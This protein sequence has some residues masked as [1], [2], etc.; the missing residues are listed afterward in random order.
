MSAVG[1]LFALRGTKTGKTAL[2]ATLW[3]ATGYGTLTVSRF[4]SRLVLAKL[5]PNAAPMG[6]VAIILL[7][8]GGLELVSDLGIGVG[9]VQHPRSGERRYM[10]T[11]FSVQVVRGVGLWAIA[12]MMAAPI[13]SL[14]HAP[15]LTGLLLFGAISTLIKAFG[16]PALW[17]HT[18][19]MTLRVPTL[20]TIA[21]ELAGFV[22]TIGWMLL[23]PTAWAIVG[24]VVATAAVSTLASHL[25]R[26]RAEFLWDKK[27]AKEIVNFGGWMVLSSATY[28]MSSRGESLM[29]RG[30]VPDIEFG[31]F[32]FASM[33]VTTP[34]AAVTA[35][36]NQVYL[37]MLAS[38]VREDANR[39]RRLFGLG[40][41][42]FTALALIFVWGAAFVAPP[43]IALMKLK[44]TFAGLAWMVPLLG[45]R[46]AQD[47]FG[48]PTASLL[49]A[50]GAPR[51]ATG[52]NV[53]R[54][55]ML[56]GG[57]Y[58]T[59]G[60]WGLRGAIWVLIAAA[61][62]SYLILLPGV[63]RYL[64]AAMKVELA[65]TLVF[66]SGSAAALLLRAAL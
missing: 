14:Y 33:L 27:V 62:V 26:P 31:C 46:S 8:L 21:S 58:L 53:V 38:A 16:N 54:L 18:R 10:G 57:L 35:L 43:I 20:V 49:L 34:V 52:L 64:P 22:V 15:A 11:A 66:W 24:G 39:A 28:F 44:S 61:I 9:I 6:D 19:N 3:S 60:A 12:S 42:A 48:S 37:P 59:L 65:T 63:R 45:I 23:S 55:A 13:A 2:S 41:W 30:S 29:I 4:V 32:A 51:Y 17:L 50:S 40:K 7:I 1:A 47:I 36:A 56:A 25:V 5:L